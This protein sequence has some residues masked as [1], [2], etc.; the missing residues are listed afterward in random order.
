MGCEINM[1]GCKWGAS[2]GELYTEHL[3]FIKEGDFVTDFE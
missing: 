2:G 3:S 1:T